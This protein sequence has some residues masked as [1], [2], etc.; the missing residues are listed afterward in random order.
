[1][2]LVLLIA[3]AG[4][5]PLTGC[6]PSAAASQ[7]ENEAAIISAASRYVREHSV[8]DDYQVQIE[9]I[10][11]GFA[12]VKVSANNASTCPTTAFLRRQNGTWTVVGMGAFFEPSFYQRYGIPETVQIK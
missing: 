2:T 3:A 7:A 5:L 9:A 11:G 12:R 8:I 4:L 10:D 6:G 1:M